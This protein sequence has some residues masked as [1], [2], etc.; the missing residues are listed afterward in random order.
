MFLKKNKNHSL[1]GFFY[2]TSLAC[3]YKVE[4]TFNMS[5]ELSEEEKFQALCVEHQEYVKKLQS[6]WWGKNHVESRDVWEVMSQ[7]E[8]TKVHQK[9]A[10]WGRYIT[11][12]SEA[13]WK[14]RGWGTV[15]PDDDIQPVGHYKLETTV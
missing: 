7:E 14:Q 9:I 3:D 12:L 2:L 11:P 5:R 13:W 6:T 8:R 1:S 4:K 15:W 10:E